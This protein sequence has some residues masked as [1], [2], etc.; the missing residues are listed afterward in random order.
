MLHCCVSHRLYRG[1]FAFSWAIVG[2]PLRLERMVSKVV[3]S[4]PPSLHSGSI[5]VQKAILE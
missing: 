5:E 4:L 1:P 2:S 3:C